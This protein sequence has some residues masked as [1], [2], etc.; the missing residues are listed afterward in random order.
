MDDEVMLDLK[1][2]QISALDKTDRATAGTCIAGVGLG[3]EVII[4]VA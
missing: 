3:A 1:I 4:T 2:P